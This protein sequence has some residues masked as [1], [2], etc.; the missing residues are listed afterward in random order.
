MK[1]HRNEK[2]ILIFLVAVAVIGFGCYNHYQQY[3]QDN[4]YKLLNEH[5]EHNR[6][7]LAFSQSVSLNP[8]HDAQD[9]IIAGFNWRKGTLEVTPQKVVLYPASELHSLG[10]SAVNLPYGQGDKLLVL[11]VDIKNVDAEPDKGTKYFVFDLMR[12]CAQK[13]KQY[14]S[15]EQVWTDVTASDLSDPEREMFY[16]VLKKGEKRTVRFAYLVPPDLEKNLAGFCIGS[17]HEAIEYRKYFL[18]LTAGDIVY[19]EHFEG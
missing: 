6:T 3:K 1:L 18:P 12:L 17:S 8:E 11:T 5:A 13:E 14:F 9:K 15:I 7:M 4:H 10:P 19:E 2:L 16:G